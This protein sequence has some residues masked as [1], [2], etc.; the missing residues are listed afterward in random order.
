[1]T[2]TESTLFDSAVQKSREWVHD[3]ARELGRPEDPHYALRVL[4]SFLHT[5]RDKLPVEETAA[6]ASQLPELLRG[7]FYEGWRPSATPQPYHDLS[8]FLDRIAL[9]GR[10]AGETEAAFAAEA[11]VRV[12]ARHIGVHEVGKIRLVLPRDIADFLTPSVEAGHGA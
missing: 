6:L 3:L 8:T 9:E 5:L 12:L 4:R 1:V 7:V 11:A 10:M 2:T